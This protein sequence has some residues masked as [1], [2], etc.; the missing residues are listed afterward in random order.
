MKAVKNVAIVSLS[1]GILGEPFVRFEVEIGLCRLKAYGLNVKCMPHAL[2]GLEY[3]KNHPE[4][5]AGIC[6][7]PSGIRT[8]T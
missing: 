6:W 3:V 4:K 5:R 7:K 1:S 8:S 2:K